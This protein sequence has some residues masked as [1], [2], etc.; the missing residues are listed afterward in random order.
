MKTNYKSCKINVEIIIL[1]SE[2]LK[3][4]L[5]KLGSFS[6]RRIFALEESSA[7]EVN[8][9]KYNVHILWRTSNL[10]AYKACI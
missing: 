9:I 8:L 7:V 1:H 10:T 5:T 4:I 3:F 6:A 2:H